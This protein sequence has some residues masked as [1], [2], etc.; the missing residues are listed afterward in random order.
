MG[1]VKADI[2][3]MLGDL[4]SCLVDLKPLEYGAG[5]IIKGLEDAQKELDAAAIKIGQS[6]EAIVPDELM[7]D[8]F[9]YNVSPIC[10]TFSVG[11][12]LDN[13]TKT[14]FCSIQFVIA[15]QICL[16]VITEAVPFVAVHIPGFYH[17]FVPGAGDCCKVI[18]DMGS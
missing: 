2:K 6:Q 17:L 9:A 18:Q 11:I 8:G 14:M 7:K 4:Q 16:C 3:K 10:L 12:V 5:D 1:K 13:F 15:S